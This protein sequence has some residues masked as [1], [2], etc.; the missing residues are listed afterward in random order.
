MA[1]T[2]VTSSIIGLLS[3]GI[4]SLIM[5]TF[6]HISNLDDKSP[7]SLIS[8]PLIIFNIAYLS[9]LVLIVNITKLPPKIGTCIT[10]RPH[11]EFPEYKKTKKQL[12]EI[13]EKLEKFKSFRSSWSELPSIKLRKDE[14]L[15]EKKDVEGKLKALMDKKVKLI[16]LD[17]F[18][19]HTLYY[20]SSTDTYTTEVTKQKN[21]FTERCSNSD[22]EILKNYSSNKEEILNNIK[23]VSK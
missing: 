7:L 14:L 10:T 8:N 5:I 2:H 22:Q 11:Y 9:I 3:L 19:G 1:G 15:K 16:V 4:P 13:D 20:S 21:Y 23:F 17:N 6:Y 18:K 12:K